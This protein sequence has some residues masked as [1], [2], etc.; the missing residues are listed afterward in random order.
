MKRP[1]PPFPLR[2]YTLPALFS[3]AVALNAARVAMKTRR[4]A[5]GASIS[6]EELGRRISHLGSGL[7]ARGAAPGDRVGLLA[8]NGPEWGVVYA[9]ATSIGA[10]IV[11][12]D[13]QLKGSQIRRFLLHSNAKFLFVSPLL[14]DDAIADA[15][16]SGLQLIVIGDQSRGPGTTTLND[17]VAE[18]ARLAGAVNITS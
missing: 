17:L 3:E 12:L 5:A 9:A 7:I 1:I 13:T 8:D 15:A 18:G 14:L 11:P 10:T 16:H 4:G 6:Y 2:T